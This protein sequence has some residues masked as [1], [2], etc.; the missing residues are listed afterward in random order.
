MEDEMEIVTDA[1]TRALIEGEDQ[2]ITVV[3]G[4]CLG[5]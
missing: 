4:L 5:V 1:I 2:I 3:I